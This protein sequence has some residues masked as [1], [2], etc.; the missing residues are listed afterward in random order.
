[1]LHVIYGTTFTGIVIYTKGKLVVES[2]GK[3]RVFT[4]DETNSIK[5]PQAE[6]DLL[7]D[8]FGDNE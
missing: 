3:E 5:D 1:M 8:Q 2:G 7:I 6:I 4:I